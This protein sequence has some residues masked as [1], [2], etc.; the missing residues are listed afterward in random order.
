MYSLDRNSVHLLKARKKA[1]LK[2][3]AASGSLTEAAK[4][5]KVSRSQ[6]YVWLKDDV[7][8]AAKFEDAREQAGELL[9]AEAWR[10]AVDGVEEPVVSMGKMVRN[11]DGSPLLVRKHSDALMQTLLKSYQP[12]RFRERTS[13][14]HTGP[15]GGPLAMKVVALQ[16]L[17]DPEAM[18]LANRLLERV[19]A[20]DP[21]SSSLRSAREPLAL[22]AGPSSGSP[23]S[24]ADRPG[25][26]TDLPPNGVHAPS[27]GQV[28]DLL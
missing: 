14:E 23:E 1:F 25:G 18:E 21:Q 2:V 19:A 10:R 3:Y 24:E 8:Y 26:E 5:V 27:V 13:V 11:D 16:V 4:R 12:G 15:G 20:G 28:G 7:D 22:E 6:H 9:V 17:G